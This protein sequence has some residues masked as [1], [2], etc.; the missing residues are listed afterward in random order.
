MGAGD[1]DPVELALE[2]ACVGGEL[3]GNKGATDG[4]ARRRGFQ[5]GDL[6]AEIG[7]YAAHAAHAGFHAVFERT[8]C[9]EL[10]PLDLVERGLQADDHIVDAMDFRELVRRWI[11]DHRSAGFQ[12]R[13]AVR[14]RHEDRGIANRRGFGHA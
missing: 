5:R 14:G 4:P 3:D 13:L 8:E 12:T 6:K 9:R 10:A 2:G 7:E 1:V 11:G